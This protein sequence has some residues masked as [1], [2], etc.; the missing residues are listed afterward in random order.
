MY[1]SPKS[2]SLPAGPIRCRRSELNPGDFACPPVR[3]P[4]GG[5]GGAV[6]YV[7]SSAI[8]P[9]RRQRIFRPLFRIGVEF[10]K[11]VRVHGDYPYHVIFIYRHLVGETIR[12]RQRVFGHLLGMDVH[13]GDGIGFR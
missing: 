11:P 8:A 3:Q 1:T 5:W 4:D 10:E 6:I 13:L 12:V 7:N 2:F 9:Q